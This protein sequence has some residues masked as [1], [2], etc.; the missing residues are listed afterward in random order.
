M[1]T[2]KEIYNELKGLGLKGISKLSKSELLKLVPRSIS[3]SNQRGNE[4]M[5]NPYKKYTRKERKAYMIKKHGQKKHDDYV[6]GMEVGSSLLSSM[7]GNNS[8]LAGLR[9]T[10]RK[11]YKRKKE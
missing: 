4:K 3:K 1:A 5:S 11:K 9:R 7:K 10:V 2:R 6:Q 8:F